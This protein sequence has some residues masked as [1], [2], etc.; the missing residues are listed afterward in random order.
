MGEFTHAKAKE[1]NS[2]T[3][4]ATS[5]THSDVIIAADHAI[6][7]LKRNKTDKTH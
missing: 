7:R 3:F 1:K 5:L 4:V 6:I 2:T